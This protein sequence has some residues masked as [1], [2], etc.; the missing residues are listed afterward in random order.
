MAA[1]NSRKIM[2]L[3]CGTAWP[4]CPFQCWVKRVVEAD[5]AAPCCF[6]VHG[7]GALPAGEF[8]QAHDFIDIHHDP[9]DHDRRVGPPSPL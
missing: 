9:F 1:V 3:P 7:Q 5:C 8:L 6:R 2:E 4:I